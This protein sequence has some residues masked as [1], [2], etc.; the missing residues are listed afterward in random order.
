MIRLDQIKPFHVTLTVE[1]FGD[2]NVE[3]DSTAFGE[4]MK[5]VTALPCDLT[6]LG[7][8]CTGLA[9]AIKWWD[10]Y[11]SEGVPVKITIETVTALPVPIILMLWTGLSTDFMNRSVVKPKQDQS[12]TG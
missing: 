7:P 2:L 10:L 3:Y 11:E 12:E 4:A 9:A 8:M 6:I 5:V 1:G